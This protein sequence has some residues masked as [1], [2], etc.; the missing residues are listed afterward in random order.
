MSKITLNMIKSDWLDNGFI[1]CL[2]DNFNVP[3]K[4]IVDGGTLD[5]EYHGNH[6]GN[7][8]ISPLLENLIDENGISNDNTLKICRLMYTK[9]NINWN[10]L[11]ATLY[12]DYD[13]IVNNWKKEENKF[14]KGRQENTYKKGEQNNQTSIGSE[15]STVNYGNQESSTTNDLAAF[16]SSNYSKDN[17]SVSNIGSHSDTTTSNGRSD[18]Y[19]DGER[20]DNTVEGERT[21]VNIINSE[22]NIGVMTTQQLLESE[23]NLWADWSFFEQVFKDIDTIL[24]TQSYGENL[25]LNDVLIVQKYG[26]QSVNGKTGTDIILT[27]KDIGTL[28]SEEINN[29]IEENNNNIKQYVTQEIEKESNNLMLLINQLS[30]RIQNIENAYVITVN[31]ESGNVTVKGSVS[32]NTYSISKK[33]KTITINNN[34]ILSIERS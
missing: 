20:N 13:P 27:P 34:S 26:I 8:I 22:A 11:W 28:S 7:K 15:T 19:K 4:N 24:V 6:S 3:W 16:N 14:I 2:T 33:S 18:N 5:L 32:T 9:Y 10:K 30:N 25:K 31:G 12:V 23:H 29:L 17:K 21:D 1:K